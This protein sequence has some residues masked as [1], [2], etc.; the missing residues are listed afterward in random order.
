MSELRYDVPLISEDSRMCEGALRLHEMNN[1]VLADEAVGLFASVGLYSALPEKQVADVEAVSKTVLQSLMDVS[2]RIKRGQIGHGVE[3]EDARLVTDAY[4]AT[5]ATALRLTCWSNTVQLEP[6]KSEK[7]TTARLAQDM[8]VIVG[9]TRVAIASSQIGKVQIKEV[10]NSERVIGG[11]GML[12][13][14]L[15]MGAPARRRYTPIQIMAIEMLARAG[16]PERRL[17]AKEVKN[18]G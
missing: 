8:S 14:L 13:R 12:K 4:L 3:Q 10:P 2:G 17:V 15:E 16:G 18:H 9:V 11:P 7:I 1:D 5:A 6:P